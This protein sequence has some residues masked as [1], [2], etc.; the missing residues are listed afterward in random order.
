MHHLARFCCHNPDC[1]TFG[2]C[3]AGNRSVR[4]SDDT[5]SPI[6]LLDCRACKARFSERKG[7]APFPSHLPQD[8]LHAVLDPL[9]E[10]CGIRQTARQVGVPRDTSARLDKVAG[11]HAEAGEKGQ[12]KK[13]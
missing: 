11:Q 4:D 9:A 5:H 8:K 7:T 3:D 13:P 10:G 12:K 1:S 6:R 2:Q